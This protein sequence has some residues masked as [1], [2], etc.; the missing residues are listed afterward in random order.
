M[1]KKVLS[2]LLALC[3]IT[4]LLPATALAAEVAGQPLTAETREDLI[5]ALSMVE[6]GGTITLTANITGDPININ[7]YVKT[8]SIDKT[9]ANFS[10]PALIGSYTGN[11][12]TAYSVV[13]Y[14]AEGVTMTHAKTT[15]GNIHTYSSTPEAESTIAAYIA[16]TD[17]TA[18]S[19]AYACV[20]VTKA[21]AKV[22]GYYPN[23]YLKKDFT[24]SAT[25]TKSTAFT[26]FPNGHAATGTI[27][28]TG[29]STYIIETSAN[30]DG[31]ISVK[32]TYICAYVTVSETQTPYATYQ[33]AITAANAATSPVTLKVNSSVLPD[34]DVVLTDK[35]TLEIPT[36]KSVSLSNNLTVNGTLSNSGTIKLNRGGS[37]T[38]PSTTSDITTTVP[39]NYELVTTT[40]GGFTTY[41]ASAA[42]NGEVQMKLGDGEYEKYGTLAEA[43]TAGKD[44]DATI[45]LA[46]DV[47]AKSS[48]A[49]V[50]VTIDLNGHTLS[51][52]A[53]SY[54]SCSDGT[55]VFLDSSTA[56]TGKVTGGSKSF[57]LINM[58]YS[59]GNLRLQSGTYEY[60]ATEGVGAIA[61]YGRGTTAETIVIGAD[62]KV[63]ST[64][65]GILI[66]K[67]ANNVSYA[68]V[69]VDIYGAI[70]ATH[71]AVF[72]NGQVTDA[73]TA[74]SVINIYDGS[75]LTGAVGIYAAGVGQWNIAGGTITADSASGIEAK[76]GIV[77]ITGGAI[78]TNGSVGHVANGNGTSTTGYALAVVDNAA[79]AGA[80]ASITGGSFN[81]SIA[82]VDDDT[83]A[84]NNKSTL[85]VTG[86]SFST[87]PGE[88]VAEGYKV[89]SGTGDYAYRVAKIPT[90]K[91]ETA[92]AAVKTTGDEATTEDA[93]VKVDGSVIA[94]SGKI[95]ATYK[96]VV[97]YTCTDG[98]TGTITVTRAE[99]VFSASPE[100]VTVGNTTYTVDVSGMSVLPEDVKVAPPAAAA[101]PDASA[102][103]AGKT[104]AHAISDA[105]A[106][107]PPTASG[108]GA[109]V[110]NE[111]VTSTAAGETTTTN[112]T[113]GTET[114][115]T[116]KK[117]VAEIVAAAKNTDTA[118]DAVKNADNDNLVVV[119]QPVLNIAVKDLV[120]D[121]SKKT[122][123]LDIS[124]QS[125]A[126]VTTKTT[127]MEDIKT[128]G[129][130]ANAVA[131]GDPVNV[132]INTPVTL[133]IPV[134][135]GFVAAG[136]ENHLFIQHT[137]H[138]GTVETVPATYNDVNSTVTS[139]INGMSP[140][141][142]FT[143]ARTCTLNFSDGTSKVYRVSDVGALPVATAPTG[144]Q[145]SGW[146]LTAA[147][148]TGYT[149][150]YT[151]F[152]DAML[153]D[154]DSKTVTATAQFANVYTGGGGVSSYALT[155]E[156]N[157]GSAIASISKS[158]GTT[159][160]LTTYKPTKTGYTFGG[161]FSDKEL[162]K[163]VTSV[164]LTANTTVYAKWTKVSA[165]S[166]TDIADGAYYYDAVLWAVEKGVT[167]G[168]T[169][170]TFAPDATCTRAQAV[171][172][173]WRA[174]GSPEPASAK[175]AFTDVTA[176]AYYYKAVLWAVEKGITKGT[177]DATFS[178]DA[179]CSRGQI[180]TFQYRAAGSPA[181][182]AV[183]PFTDVSSDAYYLNAVL[184]AVEKGITKGTGNTTFSPDAVCTRA[185]IVTFLYRQLGK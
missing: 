73:T 177:T 25:T 158:S 20:D 121:G 24:G 74:C 48:Q 107:T 27:T 139:T 39:V 87:N 182:G 63:T 52:A 76:A 173:L 155:F 171:T 90:N 135:S 92:A 109:A 163:S 131:V 145:F 96:A 64:G 167:D 72:I 103:E 81:G 108:L 156:T 61:A 154:F 15:S 116:E 137:M 140:V 60:T 129:G 70:Q 149:G 162:T 105:I 9:S 62:A 58:A 151:Q 130:E 46:K 122:L 164:K 83:D 157:G 30:A 175:N 89:F 147:E 34:A 5:T 16:R 86:G 45:Q 172:F 118:P 152:T 82:I 51:T 132:Q 160:D 110:T 54:L 37:L 168:T 134:P 56:Q 93:S 120:T 97:T 183:N 143:D 40:T 144:Q 68:N 91:I 67:A 6:D 119:V 2:I 123:K 169:A 53:N 42:T 75:V 112:V 99:S 11:A 1:K 21:I 113:I 124:A 185:Q 141:D 36:G 69:T 26:L 170:T 57:G 95:S 13:G 138:N 12:S 161:W 38:V 18:D 43:I 102:T 85:S 165:N 150:A 78:S 104:A 98:K 59:K 10:Y 66:Q 4:A 88:Y 79:Y 179:T 65:Y 178:P 71:A 126:V 106:S 28:Y 33:A 128:E 94:V 3:M 7:T 117:P 22:G 133:T 29:S 35:V 176:D 146:T 32:P 80:T 17:A 114:G 50:G 31:S 84:N 14:G 101:K 23:L 148:V 159:V 47:T 111:T 142:I 55:A 136:S 77:N 41:S 19:T 44:K 153:T 181:T 49:V 115:T 180:V 100:V 184:W 8:F 166:F 125:Q 127:A 174:S